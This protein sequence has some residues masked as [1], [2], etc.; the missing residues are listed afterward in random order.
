VFQPS[1]AYLSEVGERL[2]ARRVLGERLIVRGP[3]IVQVDLALVVTPEP[4]TVPNAV[5]GAVDH[6]VTQRLSPVRSN[7]ADPWPLGRDLTTCELEAIAANVPGVATV[8]QV[9]V[10][11]AGRPTTDAPVMVPRDGLVV[12]HDI[13]VDVEVVDASTMRCTP[14][15]AGRRGPTR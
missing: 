1:Q 12:A 2:D 15:T 8:T 10:A 6:A 14:Q 9:R 13:G 3:V 4:G 5:R 11:V 7:G